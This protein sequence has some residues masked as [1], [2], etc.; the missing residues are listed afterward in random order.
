MILYERMWVDLGFKK[1]RLI[2][3]K[4]FDIDLEFRD[5]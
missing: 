1:V 5:V 4:N 2:C 3:K